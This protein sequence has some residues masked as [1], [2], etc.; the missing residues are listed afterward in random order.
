MRQLRAVM[1]SFALAACTAGSAQEQAATAT[2]QARPAVVVPVSVP[3]LPHTIDSLLALDGE[4]V[5]ALIGEPEFVWSEAGAEM[6]RYRGESCFL[7]VFLY[8]GDGVTYVD[9]RGEMLAEPP[10]S[11]CFQELIAAHAEE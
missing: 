1:L 5:R 3:V 4:D 10:R 11:E 9:V 6:W 2:T 8:E 7:D